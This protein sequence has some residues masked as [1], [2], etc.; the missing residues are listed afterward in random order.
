MQVRIHAVHLGTQ[1]KRYKTADGKETVKLEGTFHQPKGDDNSPIR[2][3]LPEGSKLKQYQPY[4][5]VCGLTEWS[6]KGKD[7]QYRNGITIRATE[8]KEEAK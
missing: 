1:E 6:M 3:I 7:G 2:V 5:L 4:E 8:V